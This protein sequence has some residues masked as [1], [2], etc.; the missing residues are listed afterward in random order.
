M[1]SAA[2]VLHCLYSIC[3]TTTTTTT[4]VTKDKTLTCAAAVVVVT[5]V[6]TRGRVL[7]N[8]VDKAHLVA[9]KLCLLPGLAAAAAVVVAVSVVHSQG[10][11]LVT[12]VG[13]A[14]VAT[15]VGN[16]TALRVRVR[17]VVDEVVVVKGRLSFSLVLNDVR[18]PK[19]QLLLSLCLLGCQLQYSQVAALVVLVLAVVSDARVPQ[20]GARLLLLLLMLLMLK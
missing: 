10:V 4:A 15:G 14:V 1:L 9:P 6:A 7:D 8:L 2:V 18:L 12:V 13:A 20:N 5:A 17:R 3:S 19:V 16:V 11:V